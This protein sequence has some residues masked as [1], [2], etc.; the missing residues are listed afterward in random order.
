MDSLISSST[1]APQ[2]AQLEALLQQCQDLHISDPGRCI[3]LAREAHGLATGLD[4]RSFIGRSLY[5]IGVGL[6]QTADLVHASSML[7]E[8]NA[9]LYAAGDTQFQARALQAIGTIHSAS[10]ELEEATECFERALDLARKN[11]DLYTIKRTLNSWG[12]VA[13]RSANY[14]KAFEL[15]DEC[16]THLRVEPDPYLESSIL[17]NLA[18]IY[19]R[20]GDYNAALDSCERALATTGRK[21]DYR[22]DANTYVMKADTLCFLSRWSEAKDAIGKALEIA[23]AQDLVDIEA[24]AYRTLVEI[25]KN[26]G[27]DS[28]SVSWLEEARGVAEATGNKIYL[29]KL[30][31]ELG[32]A[33]SRAGEHERAE[34]VLRNAL[35]LAERANSPQLLA[36]T[37][38]ALA[39]YFETVLDVSGAVFHLRRALEQNQLLQSDANKL[40][41]RRLERRVTPDNTR[42]VQTA[43]TL[44]DLIAERQTR[45]MQIVLERM[46]TT[47]AKVREE[48]QILG[49]AGLHLER[50]ADNMQQLLE[51]IE[52][53]SSLGK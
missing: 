31:M 2:L 9:V 44:L 41:V 50:K 15:Y 48:A 16:L 39:T 28:N 4:H 10:G 1:I 36:E 27:D 30:E 22:Q 26:Q 49:N 29:Q 47:L 33:L 21:N 35:L 23:K 3:T 19:Q 6:R 37:H 13:I 25:A 53:V 14:A 18:G 24:L 11:N 32:L 20:V 5:W 38:L 42:R 17:S 40:A 43:S 46:Q 45:L 51:Q 34:Q 52:S 12:I 8:A 7:R